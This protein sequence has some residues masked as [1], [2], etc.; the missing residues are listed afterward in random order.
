MMTVRQIEKWWAAKEHAKL[1]RE[2]LAGRSE[3]VESMRG[4]LVGP[5]SAAALALVRLDELGQQSDFTSALLRAV[6][7]AQSD[8]GGWD[9]PLLTALC[10][11]ALLAHD[12]QHDR[13]AAGIAS[14]ARLQRVDGAWPREPLRRMPGDAMATAFILLQLVNDSGFRAV[15]RVD[16]AVRW[17]RSQQPGLTGDAGSLTRVALLRAASR[18]PIVRPTSI[19]LAA[20]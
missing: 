18:R 3:G 12:D 9:D 11:R 13:A 6:I 2:C 1:S 17:L 8:E 15:A 16:D 19:H 7:D 4:L 10:V 20:A 14:L 5:V